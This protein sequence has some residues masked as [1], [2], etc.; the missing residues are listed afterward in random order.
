MLGEYAVLE[1]APALVMA[2]DRRARVTLTDNPDGGY[3]IDAPSL[4]IRGA[5]CRLGGGR[6]EWVD[7]KAADADK[8][9]LAGAVIAALA[10]GGVLPPFRA[11]LDTGAFF[12]DGGVNKLGLGS[13]AALTVALA[14]AVCALRGEP[15]PEAAVLIDIH[16]QIQAGRGSGLDIAASLQGGVI[17]YR[18]DDGRP[19]IEPVKLPAGL[20][21]ACVW[22]GQSA[23]T[24]A[25]LA[26]VAA[27]RERA[28][29]D[30]AALLGRLSDGAAAGVAAARDDDAATLL[31]AAQAYAAGLAELGRASGAGII[32][33]EHVKIADVAASCGVTY[34]TCG[35]GGGDI[36][37]A[38]ATD[39]DRLA[40]FRRQLAEHHF[41]TLDL[42]RDAFGVRAD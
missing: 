8:L 24:G 21:I 26:R 37:I 14:G 35:A 31:D 12:T 32:T 40:R 7:L 41:R 33:P 27:W 39:P 25:F 22:S 29:A 6:A 2:V 13:S 23:S 16:R 19:R 9:Q 36:G 10:G 11:T 5:R 20:E 34:K 4:G 30:Y 1:G 17:D 3:V 15:M 28:P 42:A 18:L 38:L